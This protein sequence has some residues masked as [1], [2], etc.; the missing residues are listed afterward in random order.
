MDYIRYPAQS[1]GFSP[2]SLTLFY[3]RQ[4]NGATATLAAMR[5]DAERSS[6]AFLEWRREQVTCQV[7]EVRE[8]IRSAKPWISLSAAVWANL[9]DA[10][11][12]RMQDWPT[13][14]KEGLV[15][16][17]CPMAYSTNTDRVVSQI[18]LAQDLSCGRQVW[19]G[20][21]AWQMSPAATTAKIEAM[22]KLG[23]AGV[24]LFSYDGLTGGGSSE[25]YLA[26][27]CHGPFQRPAAFPAMPWLASRRPTPATPVASGGPAMRPSHG[28][29]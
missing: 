19:A 2:D 22:R 27:L 20:L 5:Q 12:N 25:Q 13:W 14:L 8:G 7:R 1:F 6:A 3:A 10:R 15:D 21:G 23:V 11:V 17:V 28:S 9:E 4:H 24:C 26:S 16:F 29:L 18:R